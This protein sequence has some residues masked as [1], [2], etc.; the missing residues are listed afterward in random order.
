MKEL[1]KNT[2]QNLTELQKKHNQDEK[3]LREY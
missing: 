2:A 3:S 1:L